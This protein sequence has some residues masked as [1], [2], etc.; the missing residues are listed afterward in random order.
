MKKQ[1]DLN[2]QE[3]D[4]AFAEMATDAAYFEEAEALTRSFAKSGWEAFRNFEIQCRSL[5]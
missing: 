5:E 3:I 1:R 4:A 2:E